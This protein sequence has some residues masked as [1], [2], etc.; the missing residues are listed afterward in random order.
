MANRKRVYKKKV[1]KKTT[2]KEVKRSVSKQV[3]KKPKQITE[4]SWK[5]PEWAHHTKGIVWW[6]GFFLFFS[7]LLAVFYY[8]EYWWGIAFVL[9]LTAVIFV[10]S[11]HKPREILCKIDHKGVKVGTRFFEWQE[12]ISFWFVPNMPYTLLYLKSTNKLISIIS[13]EVPIPKTEGVFQ[14]LS[15]HIAMEDRGEIAVDKLT[16]LLRF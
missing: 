13:V 7:T 16:R 12:L 11:F 1:V 9:L 2:K 6:I 5:A 15:K 4:I 10:H 14:L 3:Y 8:L